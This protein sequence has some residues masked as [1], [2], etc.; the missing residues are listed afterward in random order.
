MKKYLFFTLLLITTCF[1]SCS[2]DGDKIQI[3]FSV[4]E[5]KL[6]PKQDTKISIS[7]ADLDNCYI[8]VKNDF[9]ADAYESNNYIKILAYHVGSTWLYVKCRG[10]IDS[11]KITISPTHEVFGNPI[12]DIGISIEGFKMKFPGLTYNK[13]GDNDSYTSASY[14]TKFGRCNETYYF[15]NN[16]LYVFESKIEYYQDIDINR[17]MDMYNA[18]LERY[19]YISSVDVTN[20]HVYFFENAEGIRIRLRKISEY[21][22]EIMS[23]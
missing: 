10:S 9:Y 19:K 17:D 23:L 6:V 20:G 11:C 13:Y 18:M 22:Y 12:E 2:E 8:S 14:P 15:K 21:S 3:K 16:S 4:P 5:I 1:C 7:G